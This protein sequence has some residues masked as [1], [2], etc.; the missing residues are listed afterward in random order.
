MVCTNS[1]SFFNWA[2]Q[3]YIDQDTYVYKEQIVVEEKKNKSWQTWKKEQGYKLF[4]EEG[5]Y[6]YKEQIEEE[7]RNKSW[8]I[9]KEEKG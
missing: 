4:L 3:F 5:T 9:W 2:Y 8:Q 1:I 6:M 7:K